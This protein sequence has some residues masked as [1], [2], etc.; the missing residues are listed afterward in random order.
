MTTRNTDNDTPSSKRV[1]TFTGNLVAETTYYVD[2]WEPGKTSRATEE[3]FQVGGKGIN[4]SKMLRRLGADT[5]ALCFPGGVFGDACRDWLEEQSIPYAAFAEKC[6]TRSGSIIRSSL[7]PELSILGLDSRVSIE[8]VRACVDFLES[9]DGPFVLAVCGVIPNWDG[10]Q[11]QPFRDWIQRRGAQVTLALDTYGEGLDWLVRQSP[12]LVKIN[13][14]ELEMLVE[15]DEQAVD[16]PDLL[17]QVS[18][19]FNCPHWIITNGE[20]EIWR[21]QGDKLATSIQPR[22]AH[23]VSAVGCG[24]VFFATLLDGLFNHAERGQ[25]GVLERAA[26][27]ASRNAESS[28]IADFEMD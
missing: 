12:S 15:P 20:K 18:R 5:T 4:V 13:R 19:Q 23:C 16:T 24:D 6:V 14:D 11:W 9:I 17:E 8:A 28:G 25:P 26:E 3:R 27:Y 21:K 2:D 1:I 10:D 22:E 7:K